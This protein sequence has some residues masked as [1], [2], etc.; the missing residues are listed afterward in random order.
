MATYMAEDNCEE[1][2]ARCYFCPNECRVFLAVDRDRIVRT[3]KR[4]ARQPSYGAAAVALETQCHKL[5]SLQGQHVEKARA[6][7]RAPK[8]PKIVVGGH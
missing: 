7:L 4:E 6:I 5:K 8:V 3:I 1:V 2:E